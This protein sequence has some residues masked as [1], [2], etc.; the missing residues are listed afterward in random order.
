MTDHAAGWAVTQEGA[1]LVKTVSETQRGAIVTWLETGAFLVTTG[2]TNERIRAAWQAA[3]RPY[4]AELVRV[5]IKVAH[6]GDQR[7]IHPEFKS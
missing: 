4:Y 1:L 7:V 2:W 3:K 6:Y 5:T